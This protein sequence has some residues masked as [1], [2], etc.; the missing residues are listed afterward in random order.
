LIS[1]CKVFLHHTISRISYVIGKSSCVTHFDYMLISH[2]P[3]II[4]K[5]SRVTLSK[6][7]TYLT[8]HLF[9]TSMEI[10]LTSNLLVTH[11]SCI[12]GKPSCFTYINAFSN[13]AHI[14]DLS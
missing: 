12:T 6:F 1:F 10:S 3:Y 5:S 13:S 2:I 9:H 11:T 14:I 7:S 4:G 8:S